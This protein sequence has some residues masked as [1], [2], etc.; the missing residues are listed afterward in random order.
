MQVSG[1]GT[2]ACAR[3]PSFEFL[4]GDKL[5]DVEALTQRARVGLYCRQV[6]RTLACPDSKADDLLPPES[7]TL[8][9]ERQID[10]P[11]L[12]IVWLT[13]NCMRL[14]S[15]RLTCAG[16][17]FRAIDRHLDS[18]TC[19]PLWLADPRVACVVESAILRGVELC[20]YCLWAYVIMPNHVHVLL[21]PRALLSRITRGIKGASARYANLVLARVGKTFWQDESFDHWVRSASEAERIRRYIERNP[22]LAGL[23]ARPDLWRWSSAGRQLNPGAQPRVAVPPRP[24]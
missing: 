23:V 20:H 3:H 5:T 15:A 6:A 11:D 16:E 7:P 14:D 4:A 13:S 9:A 24:A 12:A 17:Q 2:P 8:A 22:V 1:T 19:G 18:A 10:F 21:R